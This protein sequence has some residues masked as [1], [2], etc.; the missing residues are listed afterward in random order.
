MMSTSEQRVRDTAHLVLEIGT[1]NVR[2]DFPGDG[3][4]K[5]EHRCERF[6]DILHSWHPDVLGLQEPLKHQYDQVSRSLT[7]YSSVGVGRDDGRAAGEFCPIFY[8][9][10]RFDL[11]KF[12]TFWFSGNSTVPGTTDW[13]SRYRRICTWAELRERRSERSFTV[14]NL[15]LDHESQHSREKS[16]ELLLTRIRERGNHDPVIV[17]GDFNAEPENPALALFLDSP[18]PTS[19]LMSVSAEDVEVGTFHGFSGKVTGGPIDHI[20]VSPE[21]RVESARVIPGDG[22]RPFPS[23]HLPVAASLSLL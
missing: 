21:W 20:F 2:C 4:Q 13:G 9:K 1:F 23:D 14:Y 6:L 15:H 18:V 22:L 12:G 3:E 7:E 10:E 17:I 11:V 19:A 8:R 16:V 5:W